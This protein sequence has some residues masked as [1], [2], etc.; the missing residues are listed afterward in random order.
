MPVTTLG[1]KYHFA[2]EEIEASYK[3]YAIC[4]RSPSYKVVVPQELEC[5][6]WTLG[7]E[8]LTPNPEALY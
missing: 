3:C 6:Q 7:S 5:K 1:D 2:G 4:P 8:I